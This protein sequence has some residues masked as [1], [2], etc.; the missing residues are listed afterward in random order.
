[1]GEQ[2][3]FTQDVRRTDDRGKHTTTNRELILLPGGGI[4]IDTPG[5]RE[6][7]VLDIDESIGTAFD[8]V[9]YFASMCKFVD[10]SHTVEPDCAVREAIESGEL[11]EGRFEN[12]IKLKK[13]ADYIERKT[14][15]K[16]AIEYKQFIKKRCKQINDIE[17]KK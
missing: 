16:A 15:V 4:V 1:M 9:E 2:R 11:S 6:L 12:Y 8:D 10:C 7:H 13:E 17:T 14:D 5:M 3:Q